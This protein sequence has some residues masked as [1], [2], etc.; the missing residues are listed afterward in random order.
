MDHSN[1]QP[2]AFKFDSYDEDDP[3]T[4]FHP[5]DPDD[6]QTWGGS[7]RF[8]FLR[9]RCTNHCAENEFG[10][11]THTFSVGETVLDSRYGASEY[12]DA[13]Q[14]VGI[15]GDAEYDVLL[16]TQTHVEEPCVFRAP[17]PFPDDVPNRR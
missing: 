9:H 1:P 8:P 7:Q 5:Y 4:W 11:V 3:T 10:R 17:R 16:F 13:G 14:V 6:V 12:H 15:R 2:E